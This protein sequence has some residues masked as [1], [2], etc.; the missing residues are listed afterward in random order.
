MKNHNNCLIDTK[1]QTMRCT[2]CGDEMPYPV[3]ISEWFAN[4]ADAFMKAHP[5]QAHEPGR[6]ML[7]KPA[8]GE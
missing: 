3:G 2:I 8:D 5:A 4:V 7:S 6:T 1:T